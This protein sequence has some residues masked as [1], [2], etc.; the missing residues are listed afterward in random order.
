MPGTD[1]AEAARVVLGELP[2][3]PHLPEL[4]GRGPGAEMAGRAVALLVDMPA[5]VTPTGWR[6]AASPGRDLRR[7]RGYLA[8]DL[9]ALEEAADGYQGPLKI[10][11]CGPWTLAASVELPGQQPVL[12][13]A[14]AARDLAGSLAEGIAAHC[15]DVAKRVPGARLLLQLDEPRLPAVLGGGVRTASGLRRLPPPEE[16]VVQDGLG[17]TLE[18]VRRRFPGAEREPFGIIHCCARG[19]PFGLLRSAGAD[20]VSF[21][22]SLLRGGGA[23]HEDAFAET[24]EAGLGLLAGVF[25]AERHAQRPERPERRS[26]APSGV[27]ATMMPVAELWRRLGLP[28]GRAAEQVV[29]TPACGLAGAAP[30]AARSALARCRDAAR[31]LAEEMAS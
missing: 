22:L 13:D 4:P 3:L 5:V 16:A 27:T 8:H 23:A 18:G 9:D 10:G 1:P 17:A 25:D 14:G 2:D 6:L 19:V 31:A 12:A 15:A 20:A 7:A 24:A 21:D 26:G 11:V 29:L 30:D 28:P